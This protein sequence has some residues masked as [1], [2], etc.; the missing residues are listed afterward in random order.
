MHGTAL[1]AV[2]ARC[3]PPP[4][5]SLQ[6]SPWELWS[7][8]VLCSGQTSPRVFHSPSSSKLVSAQAHTRHDCIDAVIVVGEKNKTGP[9]RAYANILT[10]QLSPRPEKRKLL[11]CDC[12]SHICMLH[13]CGKKLVPD[14]S[15]TLC[16]VLYLTPVSLNITVTIISRFKVLLGI[17]TI[18]SIILYMS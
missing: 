6:L 4:W 17:I 5:P 2:V 9:A 11:T 1:P 14:H 3:G 7:W 18:I 15:Q 16:F 12:P 10:G 8:L 13:L